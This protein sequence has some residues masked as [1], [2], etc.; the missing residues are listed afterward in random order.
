MKGKAKKKKKR[1]SFIEV[2]NHCIKIGWYYYYT[3]NYGIDF[4]FQ[5]Y[6]LKIHISVAS[7]QKQ[8][9]YFSL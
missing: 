6:I 2:T 9:F 5:P 3:M 8:S 7:Q 1:W 4:D